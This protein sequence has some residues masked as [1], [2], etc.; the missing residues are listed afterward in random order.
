MKIIIQRVSKAR[1]SSE[2]SLLGSIARG[3]VVLLGIGRE[4]TRAMVDKYV[5]KIIKLRIFED[6]QGKTNL[7]L[8]D[9]GGEVLVVSQ[10]TLYADTKKRKPPSFFKCCTT[11]TGRRAL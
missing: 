8:A 3:Y 1:V 10:F 5:E 4:D 7:S 11:K 6:E 2:G 9:V